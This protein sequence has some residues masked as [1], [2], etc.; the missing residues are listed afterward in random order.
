VSDVGTA[1]RELARQQQLLRTLWR[2]DADAA[3]APEWR[4]SA[5]RVGHGIEAYRGN[6]AA[7]AERTLSSAFPTVRQLIGEPS[8][9][10][11]AR[12]FWHHHA[13]RCGDLARYG[14]GLA[15]WIAVD[16][17]LASEPYLAD[18]A[19]VDWAVHTIEQAADAPAEPAGLSLLAQHEPARLRLRLQP[20]LGWVVSRWPVVTIWQAHRS[21]DVDRFAPVR[22]AFAGGVAETALVARPQWRGSVSVVGEAAVRFMGAL[23]E[24]AD[25]AGALDAAGDAF[26]FEPWL[27]DAVRQHW[28]QAV[29]HADAGSPGGNR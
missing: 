27:H 1:Q 26:Q 9:G 29:Q 6:A 10:V 14:D 21:R 18:V 19:R 15:D 24:G 22:Q 16:P 17:Q 25:L 12:V 28:L 8:F 2:K 20:A 7:I 11:L 3:S 13:P 5:E 23:R 4:E